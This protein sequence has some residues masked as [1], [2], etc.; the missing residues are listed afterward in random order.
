MIGQK[1]GRAL[2]KYLDQARIKQK[3]NTNHCENEI[4]ESRVG[5][6]YIQ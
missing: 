3:Y 2:K 1:S 4:S 5:M 6:S